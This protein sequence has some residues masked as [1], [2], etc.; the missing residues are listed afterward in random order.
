MGGPGLVAARAA[1]RKR[2][3]CSRYRFSRKV[4]GRAFPAASKSSAHVSSRPYA[5][6]VARSDLIKAMFATYSQGDHAG[7]QRAAREVIDDER[8]KRHV[9]LADELEGLLEDGGAPTP[10]NVA[11]LQPLPRGRDEIP[12]VHIRAPERTLDDV[13]LRSETRA[14]V[15]ELVREF[16]SASILHAHGLRPRSRGLFVGPPGTGKSLTAEALAGELGLPLITID[17]A[18]V[19]SSYLGET[20]RNLSSIFEFCARGSW[21]VLFDEFDALAKERADDSEHGELKRVV[22]AFL[23]LLDGFQG[24]S[25]LLAASNHPGLMDDAVWRR[26][27]EVL[28][29]GLPTQVE[30][31]QLTQMK[32]RATRHRLPLRE[33]ARAMKGFSHAEVEMVCRDALRRSVLEEHGVV[34]AGDFE[35]A[36][37]RMAER[38]R[39]IRRARG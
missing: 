13:V 11:T 1:R 12:L 6:R 38:R 18:T 34:K 16:R 39:T 17:I 21:V 26:F 24:R 36:I 9:L 7:F 25:L 35:Q 28:E 4:A 23:Q 20:S 30:I 14:V 22:T 27:D 32:L 2:H 33:L 31:V 37:E 29:F 19:V 3:A 10:L 8:R 5:R 15:E